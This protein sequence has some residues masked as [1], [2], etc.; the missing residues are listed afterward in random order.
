MYQEDEYLVLSGLQHFRFCR[1]QWA[2]IHV[3]QQ[4]AENGRTT[5]GMLFH[6]NA[7][8]ASK[9]EKRG[10]VIT[11]RGLQVASGELGVRGIC[12]VVEFHRE[13]N[14]ISLVHYPGT[15]QPIPIEY[16]T[17]APKEHLADE[18]QLCCQAMCLEEMLLCTI[19][20]GYLF[21]GKTKRRVEVAFTDSLR[22]EVKNSLQEMHHY[23]KEGYTPKPKRKKSCGAC[24]LIDLCIPAL[25]V[26]K[27]V[28][29]YIDEVLGNDA[30]TS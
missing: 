10:D 25:P 3:E 29:Q 13:E 18:L 2:L 8:D 14:G 16:K 21:Y 20:M 7:H 4:W 19:P 26:E 9:K 11:I 24:S 1:R 22:Q 27:S 17:G 6:K 15:W 30:K 5:D 12:D 28:N 23:M